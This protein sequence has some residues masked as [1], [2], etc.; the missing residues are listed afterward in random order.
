MIKINNLNTLIEETKVCNI[1]LYPKDE[2]TKSEMLS[3]EEMEDLNIRKS[4][5]LIYSSTS[6]NVELMNCLDGLD[7]NGH[8]LIHS[9]KI[10]LNSFTNLVCKQNLK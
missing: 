8:D 10:D 4:N 3:N 7:N 1:N 5:L 6:S 9:I 2:T